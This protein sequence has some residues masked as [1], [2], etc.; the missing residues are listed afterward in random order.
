MFVKCKLRKGNNTFSGAEY[1]F[2][3]AVPVKIGDYV[4]VKTSKGFN[5]ALVTQVDVPESEI[6]ER[7]INFLSPVTE[8]LS[9]I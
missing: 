4:L 7:F 5:K 6:D 3:C 1:A 9:E 2:I 8:N